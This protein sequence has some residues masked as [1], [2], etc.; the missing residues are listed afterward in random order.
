MDDKTF[1]S[2]LWRVNRKILLNTDVEVS[3][4]RGYSI[5]ISFYFNA[6]W[7]FILYPACIWNSHI[8]LCLLLPLSS[9]VPLS[10]YAGDPDFLILIPALKWCYV[11]KI[12]HNTLY[13]SVTPGSYSSFSYCHFTY[14]AWCWKEASWWT[15]IVFCSSPVFP[16]KDT[17]SSSNSC[18]FHPVS[19]SLLC[20]LSDFLKLFWDNYRFPQSCEM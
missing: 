6:Q 13:V 5:S 9:R 14:S 3:I 8:F 17:H 11:H 7:K 2:L 20:T 1:Y 10:W 18:I 4:H 19:Q 15:Q 12:Q 16:H